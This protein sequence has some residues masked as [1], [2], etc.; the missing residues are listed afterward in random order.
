[1]N[2]WVIWAHSFFF[3]VRKPSV[4]AVNKTARGTLSEL[5]PELGPPEQPGRREAGWKVLFQDT[6][7]WACHGANG[8]REATAQKVVF[9]FS[10]KVS[11]SSET[12]W[13]GGGI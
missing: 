10:R 2:K 11:G 5:C 7:G 9:F 13:G 3:F 8:E 12:L 4:T 6:E 1:M